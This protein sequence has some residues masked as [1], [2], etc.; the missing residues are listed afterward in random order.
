[1]DVFTKSWD[2]S[3][4]IDKSVPGTEVATLSCI[5]PLL[6]NIINVAIILSSV[7]ALIFIIWSGIQI[8]TANGDPE[9]LSGAKKTLTFAIIGFVFITLVFVFYNGFF[10]LL[11]ID[12]TVVSPDP[13][14]PDRV[15]IDPEL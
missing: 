15:K 8:I 5:W 1:M 3:N 7:V 14:D 11:G 12:Q 6:S 2:E 9:K 13:T 4:C 10:E